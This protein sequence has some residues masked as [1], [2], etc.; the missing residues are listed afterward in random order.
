MFKKLILLTSI[1]AVVTT[2]CNKQDAPMPDNAAEI[3]NNASSINLRG[4]GLGLGGSTADEPTLALPEPCFYEDILGECQ[5]ELWNEGTPT[6]EPLICD[7]TGLYTSEIS[8]TTLFKLKFEEELYFGDKDLVYV[9]L[10]EN[11]VPNP[12]PFNLEIILGKTKEVLFKILSTDGYNLYLKE[13]E[14]TISMYEVG[15]GQTNTYSRIDFDF[16]DGGFNSLYEHDEFN[17]NCQLN[18]AGPGSGTIFIAIEP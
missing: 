8:D 3:E 2:A 7:L 17:S 12:V 9:Q 4:G 6:I 16:A 5:E 14:F 15:I 1:I 13:I 18:N 11:G 10:F